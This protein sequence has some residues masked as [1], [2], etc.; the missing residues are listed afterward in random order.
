MLLGAPQLLNGTRERERKREKE[1]ERERKREKQ[2]PR[3]LNRADRIY[4]GTWK[5]YHLYFGWSRERERE[6]EREGERE[7]ERERE[8]ESWSRQHCF[9]LLSSGYMVDT[10]T[11]I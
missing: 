10:S 3:K 9:L 4:N 1:R 8:R 7:R 5:Q 6:R 2:F 11:L